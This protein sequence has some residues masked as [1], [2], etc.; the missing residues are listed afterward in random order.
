M[1]DR[2]RSA[3]NIDLIKF[4]QKREINLEANSIRSKIWTLFDRDVGW[5]FFEENDII[6]IFF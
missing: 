5:S 4:G 6:A 1:I 3:D 2:E